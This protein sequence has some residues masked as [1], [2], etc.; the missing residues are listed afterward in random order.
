[1][2]HGIL[3]PPNSI[4][5]PGDQETLNGKMWPL[6][7]P[8]APGDASLMIT[9]NSSGTLQRRGPHCQQLWSPV[10]EFL[11][12]LRKHYTC[13]LQLSGQTWN[14]NSMKLSEQSTQ[15]KDWHTAGGEK[16]LHYSSLLG[17]QVISAWRDK[18]EKR[19]TERAS[20]KMRRTGQ[21]RGGRTDG[22]MDRC[23]YRRI[24]RMIDGYTYMCV[25]TYM[26]WERHTYR[27][28]DPRATK[29]KGTMRDTLH[30]LFVPHPR[31]TK[32]P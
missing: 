20:E 29:Q 17:R 19:Q 9:Q 14:F 26:D 28:I 30:S 5:T 3:Q 16:L 15:E 27:Y 32:A 10:L 1:M 6:L 23:R 7:R 8:R 12:T 2:F 25:R 24:H 4:H 13:M 21:R 22:Q 18:N 11:K 31:N